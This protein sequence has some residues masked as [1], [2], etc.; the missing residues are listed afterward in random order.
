MLYFKVFGDRPGVYLLQGIFLLVINMF[1][2]KQERK[3]IH[4]KKMEKEQNKL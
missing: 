1:I 3:Q 2:N 4:L